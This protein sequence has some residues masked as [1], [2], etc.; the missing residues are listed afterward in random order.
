MALRARVANTFKRGERTPDRVKWNGIVVWEDPDKP[1][2]KGFPS[3]ILRVQCQL[4]EGSN[5]PF[6]SMP[7][8]QRLDRATGQLRAVQDAHG[9]WL[10]YITLGKAFMDSG[11]AA[12]LEELKKP[13][14]SDLDAARQAAREAGDEES[15]VDLPF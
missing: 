10:R 6:L 8:I 1:N 11:V 15:F 4:I 12:V 2:E 7:N 14:M 9:N 5:G 3:L 13:T